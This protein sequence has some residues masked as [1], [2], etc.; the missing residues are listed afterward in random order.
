M[1]YREY[2]EDFHVTP[3]HEPPPAPAGQDTA[4]RYPDDGVESDGGEL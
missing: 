3:R 4:P 2:G 1:T